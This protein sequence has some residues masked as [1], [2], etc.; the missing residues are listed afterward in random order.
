MI[1][2]KLQRE[3]A[4]RAILG[5]CVFGVESGLVGTSDGLN[6][7]YFATGM[8]SC[9]NAKRDRKFFISLLHSY[10]EVSAM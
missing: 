6:E 4:V 1:S 7:N 2:L 5:Q 10:F 9:K 3:V 8:L